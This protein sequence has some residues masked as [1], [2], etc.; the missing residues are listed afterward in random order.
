LIVMTADLAVANA[1]YVVTVPQA[2]LESRPEVLRIIEEAENRKPSSGPFRIH[3]M[4]AWHPPVWQ[5]TPSVDR[6]LE[7]VVWEHDTLQPK[8]GINL[9]VEYT[10]TFGVA[11]LSSYNELFDSFFR[12]IQDPEAARVLGVDVGKTVVYYPRR[13]FDMWNTRYFVI[14]SYP[15][16]WL[17]NYRGYAAFW[18]QSDPVYP[19]SEALGRPGGAEALKA[20]RVQDYQ[21][22][23]NQNELPRAWVVHDARWHRPVTG[24]SRD[25]I[26][27]EILYPD[28]PIWHDEARRAFD[29]RRLAWLEDDKQSELGPYLSGGMSWPSE[30]VEVRYPTPL[31]VELEATLESPGLVVLADVD[32]PGWELTIDGRPA[33]IHRVNWLMRGA[34]VRAGTHHLVY[35][36]APRSFRIGGVVSILGLGVLAL[37]G[38]A[39]ARRPVDR[40]LGA[41]DAA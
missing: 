3:R 23:R 14:P 13:S 11:G 22:R 37:L 31:S 34:A 24:L 2:V 27:Q 9:G 12:T 35:S 28:D 1:R 38:V 15:H 39:C 19:D 32:Y 5:T 16:G 6:P 21:V 29:P 36:Y 7:V 4:P 17:D 25:G 33:P 10:H 18:F 20:S 26:L 30:R 41:W 40:G 8:F